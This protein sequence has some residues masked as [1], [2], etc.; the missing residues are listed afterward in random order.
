MST[1]KDFSNQIAF[2]TRFWVIFYS[3]FALNIFFGIIL[4]ALAL[5]A[6]FNPSFMIPKILWGIL[7]LFGVSFL[8]TAYFCGELL[9]SISQL[10]RYTRNQEIRAKSVIGARNIN[11][12]STNEMERNNAFLHAV[13]ENYNELGKN[14]NSQIE[15]QRKKSEEYLESISMK[16]KDLMERFDRSS[17][18]TKMLIERKLEELK[19]TSS[20]ISRSVKEIEKS[21]A[22]EPIEKENVEVNNLEDA[23]EIQDQDE[24]MDDE[25]SNPFD[26]LIMDFSGE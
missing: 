7:G 22:E 26:D 12:Y 14:I 16:F 20:E 1:D 2:K 24:A 25:F 15:V 10:L 11:E 3:I 17:D 9:L 23:S 4:V 8:F 13:E 19:K 18:T 6:I 5:S 21:K